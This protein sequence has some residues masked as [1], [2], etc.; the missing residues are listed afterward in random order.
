MVSRSQSGSQASGPE[1]FP[2]GELDDPNLSMHMYRAFQ[3]V[4]AARE[5]MWKCL[6]EAMKNGEGPVLESFGWDMIPGSQTE[7]EDALRERFDQRLERF[8]QQMN[9]RC[10]LGQAISNSLNWDPPFK[11]PPT[12][13]E[14]ARMEYEREF[15]EENNLARPA[16]EESPASRSIRVFIGYKNSEL[17]DI[18]M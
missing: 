5:A 13:K 16:Y 15:V 8:A 18:R 4:L 6:Q 12:R 2:L 7:E 1:M 9:A 3:N 17:A 14:L 10:G 11:D